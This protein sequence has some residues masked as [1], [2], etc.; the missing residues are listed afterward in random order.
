MP[1]VED[2][3][4]LQAAEYGTYQAIA[5]ILHNGVLAYNVGDAVPVSNV[6]QYGYLEQGF[7]AEIGAEVPAP[8][9]PP[10]LPVGDPIVINKTKKG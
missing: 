3:A 7:V 2:Y 6:E 10:A 5:P 8:P 9:T 1:T 4:A